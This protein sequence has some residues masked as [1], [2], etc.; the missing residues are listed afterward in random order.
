M[1]TAVQVGEMAAG[2]TRN[3]AVSFVDE[4]D[5]G[6]LLT[7]TPTVA[8]QTTSDLMISNAVVSSTALTIQGESV[9]S[10]LAVTFRVTGGVAGTTYTI[11]IT[12][13]TDA[14]LAQTVIGFVTLV[15]V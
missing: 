13:T 1:S 4:L 3:A 6:E 5:S 8:E 7:G 2:E 14:A 15:V 9:A 10:G 11:K 12:A